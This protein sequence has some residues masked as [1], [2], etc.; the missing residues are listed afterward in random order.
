MHTSYESTYMVEQHVVVRPAWTALSGVE[1]V[2]VYTLA[3]L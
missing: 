3:A 2:L 1:F